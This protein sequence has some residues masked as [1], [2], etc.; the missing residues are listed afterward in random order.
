MVPADEAMVAV[1]V[2]SGAHR[3]EFRYRPP[4]QI[5]GLVISA[6]ATITIIFV[7]LHTILRGRRTRVTG[8]DSPEH[9]GPGDLDATRDRRVVKVRP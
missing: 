9:E 4:R 3:V 7:L 6:I 8:S 5:A 1:A 2:P